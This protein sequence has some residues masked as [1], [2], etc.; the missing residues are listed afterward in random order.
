M[1]FEKNGPAIWRYGNPD[2]VFLGTLKKNFDIFDNYN[3]IM[4]K[5]III[6][7]FRVAIE[8]LL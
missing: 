6:F 5:M 7:S 4:F 3:P 2:M 8:I 1:I